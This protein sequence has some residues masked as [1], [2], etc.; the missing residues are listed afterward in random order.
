MLFQKKRD[1]NHEKNPNEVHQRQTGKEASKRRRDSQK[2]GRIYL[3]ERLYTNERDDQ[4]TENESSTE[5]KI[6]EEEIA[7][8][9]RKLSRQKAARVDEITTELLQALG[10]QG[11]G[12]IIALISK[13]NNSGK[14]LEE[15]CKMVFIL[16]VIKATDCGDYRAISLIS[17]V[18]KILLHVVKNE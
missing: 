2:M 10:K 11:L 8:V 5:T 4:T 6:T 15:I 1:G 3:I 14:T 16:K 7:N 9:I 12:A 18:S 13:I 17:H